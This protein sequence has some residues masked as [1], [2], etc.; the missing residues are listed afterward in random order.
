[1]LG[2][3]LCMRYGCTAYVHVPLCTASIRPSIHT[4]RARARRME[5]TLAH[6]RASHTPCTCTPYRA[7]HSPCTPYPMLSTSSAR[8]LWPSCTLTPSMMSPS[9]AMKVGG[10]TSRFHLLR[11][12]ARLRLRL[13]LR[14]PEGEG[15]NQVG[16]T[17][18]RRAQVCGTRRGTCA[19]A[20]TCVK[21]AC[22]VR[23]KRM[24]CTCAQQSCRSLNHRQR[25]PTAR[26]RSLRTRRAAAAPASRWGWTSEY[27]RSGRG[28][29]RTAQS[30]IPA[31]ETAF[32][33]DPASTRLRRAP[34]W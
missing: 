20:S 19:C 12:R 17:S 25:L 32:R 24:G 30:R 3:R 4:A 23:G 16:P 9:C 21:C 6:A 7:F 27:S 13:R 10:S 18:P 14:L 15:S 26:L 11:V 28:R 33:R 22:H 2:V 29:R 1:M 8:S 31:S 34:S 5:C